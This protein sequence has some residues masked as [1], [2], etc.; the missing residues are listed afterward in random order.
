MPASLP[1]REA[2]RV[3]LEALESRLRC[4]N[5]VGTGMIGRN[6]PRTCY[7]CRGTGETPDVRAALETWKARRPLSDDQEA[8]RAIGDEIAA[9]LMINLPRNQRDF[10]AAGALRAIDHILGRKP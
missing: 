1:T 5:C 4:S 6:P 7:A 10:V 9:H 3:V 8:L 2:L